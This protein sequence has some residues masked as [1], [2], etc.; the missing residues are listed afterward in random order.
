MDRIGLEEARKYV[1]AVRRLL[2]G[3]VLFVA[4]SSA[5]TAQTSAHVEN[6]DSTGMLVGI[7]LT[8]D[9]G[10]PLSYAIVSTASLGRD[11]FTDDRGEFRLL[12]VPVGPVQLQVCHLGYAPVTMT[13]TV[14]ANRTDTLRVLLTHI[15]VQL[16][17]VR[18]RAY[19]SCTDPG[20]PKA[21]ADSSFAT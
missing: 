2:R 11:R 10:I 15:A 14:H 8:K 1:A 12:G 16:S 3:W 9:G 4:I 13:T 18:V 6:A 19:P 20:A 21:D 17:A 7:V 5:A